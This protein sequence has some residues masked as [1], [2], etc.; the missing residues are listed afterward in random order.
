MDEVTGSCRCGAVSLV[1]KGRPYRVGLC[2][3]M[4]CRKQYGA[5]FGALAIFPEHAV[6]VTG[7]TSAYKDRHFCPHCGSQ[8]YSRWEDEIEITLGILDSPNQFR[9]TYENWNLHREHWLPPFP[10]VRSYER[11]RGPGRTED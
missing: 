1:A 4:D 9:P 5:V 6:T 7:K 10:G 2:H 3:C 8:V 11:N